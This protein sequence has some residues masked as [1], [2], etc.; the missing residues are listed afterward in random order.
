MIGGQSLP[1]AELSTM[2]IL[3]VG[4]LATEPWRWAGLVLARRVEVDSPLFRLARVVSN[5]IVAAFVV[6]LLVSPPGALV[7]TPLVL[8]LVAFA[9]ACVA[10]VWYRHQL[11]FG[12]LVG[13]GI[14]SVGLAFH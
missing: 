3:L 5:A 1:P 11:W 14:L 4:F 10:F 13:V 7:D 6:R 12:V 8:R 2:T 9:A